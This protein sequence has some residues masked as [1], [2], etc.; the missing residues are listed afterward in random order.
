MA[1]A[2]TAGA[3]PARHQVG[4][5]STSWAPPPRTLADLPKDAGKRTKT[6]A[7]PARAGMSKRG[8]RAERVAARAEYREALVMAAAGARVVNLDALRALA[9][10]VAFRRAPDTD[11][12]ADVGGMDHALDAMEKAAGREVPTSTG[13]FDAIVEAYHAGLDVRNERT[14][15]RQRRAAEEAKAAKAAAKEA[16]AAEKAAK[17]AAKADAPARRSRPR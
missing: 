10:K 1:A 2:K 6:K 9:L 3:E 8:L 13:W 14:E 11:P 17:A 4:W 15:T 7:A 5:Q 12:D 16:K